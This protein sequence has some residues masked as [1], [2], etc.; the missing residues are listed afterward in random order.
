MNKNI[1]K[2]LYGFPLVLLTCVGC[3]PRLFPT[4]TIL[5]VGEEYYLPNSDEIGI[6]LTWFSYKEVVFTGKSVVYY[7]D[8]YFQENNISEK[9]PF[10]NVF[11]NENN[12]ALGAGLF[13]ELQI[14]QVDFVPKDE[15]KHS[16]FLIPYSYFVPGI[17]EITISIVIEKLDELRESSNLFA[18][19]SV[20]F[21]Y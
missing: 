9:G 13:N 8:A 12:F 15:L 17:N 3:T 21:Y 14:N 20:G 19:K 1:L 2:K 18:F 4:E 7:L 11:S 10:Y 16:M 6:V 5:S